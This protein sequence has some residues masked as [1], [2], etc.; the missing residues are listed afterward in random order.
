MHQGILHTCLMRL[1]TVICPLVLLSSGM[2]TAD[3][4]ELYPPEI[5][6]PIA[7]RL[8]DTGQYREAISVLRRTVLT[9]DSMNEVLFLTGLSFVELAV[10]TTDEKVRNERLDHA[11]AAFRAILSIQPNLTRVRLEL[12][13]TFFLQR[14]DRLAR[15][16][17]ERV[18]ASNPPPPVIVKI[19]RFLYQ[20]KARRRWRASASFDFIADSNYNNESDQKTILVDLG[21]G[22]VLPFTS[23]S[24]QPKSGFGLAVS[25]RMGYRVPVTEIIQLDFGLELMRKELPGSLLDSTSYTLSFGPDFDISNRF[26][27]GFRGVATVTNQRSGFN[28]RLG[29]SIYTRHVVGTRTYLSTNLGLYERS[30]K[31]VQYS[32]ND[33]PE[34]EIGASVAHRLSP[35]FTLKGSLS[36]SQAKPKERPD[37]HRRTVRGSAGFTKDFERG[38]TVGLTAILSQTNFDGQSGVPTR[39]NLP[40]TDRRQTFE[41]TILK[42]DWTVLGFSPQLALISESF[43]SNA[44]ASNTQAN[45]LQ[46]NLVRQF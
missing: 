12:A 5:T 6:V 25:G 23:D 38:Y 32:I 10:Q 21:D 20:I 41:A 45:R 1:A 24:D 22:L 44:Q 18:L 29:G 17:F 37:S 35:T 27:L 19:N 46:L 15:E 2:S 40:R 42:R 8:H 11:V 14:K 33:G 3:A 4:V 31:D 28:Q 9:P 34:Y 30:Y 36:F 39:D 43:K 13:R 26:V 7:K 16:H